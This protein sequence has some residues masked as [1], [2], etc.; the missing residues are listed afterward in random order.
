[1]AY[2][3]LW[4][5]GP[6]TAP[7]LD[8]RCEKFLKDEFNLLLDFD[9]EDALQKLCKNEIVQMEEDPVTGE[10]HYHALPIAKA[11]EKLNARWHSYVPN[12][13]IDD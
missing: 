8:A 4:Q 6:R 5:E 11:L 1:M 7:E 12:A 2:Y 3:F 9:I 13:C 10:V